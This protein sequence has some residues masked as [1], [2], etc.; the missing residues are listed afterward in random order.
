MS[1]EVLE[2]HVNPLL[3]RREAKLLVHHEGQGTPDRI[4][5]RKL[6][7]E[8]FKSKIESVFVRSISTRTGGSSAICRVDLYENPETA[9][10]L[11]P[12]YLKNRNLPKERRVSRQKKSAEAPAPAPAVAKPSAEKPAEKKAEPAKPAKPEKKETTGAPRAK[13]PKESKSPAKSEAKPK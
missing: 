2:E 1:F 8:H 3:G 9:D 12:D 13:E 4:T 7:S 5:V 6:A 11:V 10:K